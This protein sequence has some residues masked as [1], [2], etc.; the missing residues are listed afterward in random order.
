MKA[1]ILPQM[2]FALVVQANILIVALA[3]QVNVLVVIAIIICFQ[4]DPHVY[5]VPHI[6]TLVVAVDASLVVKRYLIVKHV[7]LA[8]LANLVNH[9][10]C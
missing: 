6:T 10:F 8:E 1:D 7:P 4:M 9:P 2:M 5:T 3:I